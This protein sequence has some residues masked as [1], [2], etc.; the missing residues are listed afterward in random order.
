MIRDQ[1]EYYSM[2]TPIVMPLR[3]APDGYFRIA[4]DMTCQ[5][6]GRKFVQIL[7]AHRW[8]SELGTILPSKAPDPNSERVAASLMLAACNRGVGAC[9]P[10]NRG[11]MWPSPEGQGK[12][13]RFEVR[14]MLHAKSC[15][16]GQTRRFGPFTLAHMEKEHK[17]LFAGRA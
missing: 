14:P 8:R 15:I 11:L 7:R 2:S 4:A 13:Y 10:N 12:V 1:N 9:N 17:S 5:R 6:C 16:I 3:F